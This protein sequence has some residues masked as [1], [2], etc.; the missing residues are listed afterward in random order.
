MHTYEHQAT[1]VGDAYVVIQIRADGR[2]RRVS[3]AHYDYQRWCNEGQSCPLVPAPLPTPQPKLTE[4]AAEAQAIQEHLAEYMAALAAWDLAET[5][6]RREALTAWR[7][8]VDAR[9]VALLA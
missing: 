7:L 8:K 3:S 6:T 1:G 9:V 2:R 4:A 5:G